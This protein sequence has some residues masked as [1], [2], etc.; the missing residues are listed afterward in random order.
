LPTRLPPVL[1]RLLSLCHVDFSPAHRQPSIYRLAIATAVS[2][3]AS[4]LADAV[5]VAIA[6]A[7]FPST[8]GYGHFRFS[9]YGKLTVVGVVIACVA[10]PIITRI[11][12]TPKWL[13]LRL[14]ILVTLVLWLPDLFILAKGQ[15]PMAVAVLM[16]MHV[17]IALITYN[18]VVHLA[19]VEEQTQSLSPASAA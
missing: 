18:C 2:V 7:V 5:L 6:T 9:D 12:S 11:S 1:Q 17:A 10:W 8:K 16:V 13:Y 14:A 15:P 4:L 19:K 3:V